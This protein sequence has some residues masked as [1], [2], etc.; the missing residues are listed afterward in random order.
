MKDDPGVEITR[1]EP[2]LTHRKFWFERCEE[3]GS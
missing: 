3:D 1:D 2:E